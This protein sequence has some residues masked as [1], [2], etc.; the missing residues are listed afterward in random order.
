MLNFIQYDDWY[1]N[2]IYC[3]VINMWIKDVVIK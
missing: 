2:S 3:D 1:D